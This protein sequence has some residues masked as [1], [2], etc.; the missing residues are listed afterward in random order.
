MQGMFQV[1]VPAG[2]SEK[3]VSEAAHDMMQKIERRRRS[4]GTNSDDALL[5]HARQLALTWLNGEVEPMEVVWSSRQNTRW[6]S[7]TATSGRIRL[8]T[9]LQ[10]MPQWVQDGVLVHELAH[11]KHSGHGDEFQQLAQRYPRQ[12]EVTAFLEGVTFAS[13]RGITDTPDY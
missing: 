9:R 11:L 10:E 2:L 6:G 4:A 7:C 12:K 8:S 5:E 1:S 13:G 3:Q